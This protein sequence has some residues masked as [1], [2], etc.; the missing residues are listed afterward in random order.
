MQRSETVAADG[1]TQARVE[2]DMAVGELRLSGGASD[3]MEAD[4]VYDEELEP[5]VDYGLNGSQGTLIV[6]QESSRNVR[7]THNEWD[8][9]LN[10]SIPVEVQVHVASAAANLDLDTVTVLALNAHSASGGVKISLGG[11]QNQATRIAVESASGRIS[12]KLNGA[13][14]S[15]AVLEARSASGQ[16][17]IDLGG[18]FGRSLEARID[19]VS[20][21][22]RVMIPTDVGVVIQTSTISGRVNWQTTAPA[23]P[24]GR[25]YMNAAYQ[26]APVKLDLRIATISG[27]ITVSDAG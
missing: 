22:A 23:Q 18:T 16:V 1:A 12:L 5:R 9:R 4:F 11:D 21:R 7:S 2:I 3:L 27:G 8:I 17:E 25:A 26:S 24:G 15:L 6:K 10:D 19:S 14:R 20:G 13:Y